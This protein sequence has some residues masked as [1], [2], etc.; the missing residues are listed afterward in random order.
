MSQIKL[1]SLGKIPKIFY[2][3]EYDNTRWLLSW[4]SDQNCTQNYVRVTILSVYI[5][6]SLPNNSYLAQMQGLTPPSPTSEIS[7]IR[8][9]LKGYYVTTSTY[10]Y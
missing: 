6:E 7:C 3:M 9:C 4:N 5:G 2:R 8:H 10:M 1:H